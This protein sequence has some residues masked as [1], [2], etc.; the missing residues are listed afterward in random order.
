MLAVAV[1]LRAV[2]SFWWVV[3]SGVC[4]GGPRAN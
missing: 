1:A 2:A 3:G 4:G